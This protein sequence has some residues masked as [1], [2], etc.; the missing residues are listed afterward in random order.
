VRR[1]VRPARLAATD[2][3]AMQRLSRAIGGAILLA[4]VMATPAAAHTLS[5]REAKRFAQRVVAELGATTY[6]TGLGYVQV[7]VRRG[8]KDRHWVNCRARWPYAYDGDA[9]CTGWIGVRYRSSH[10]RKKSWVGPLLEDCW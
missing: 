5:E 9:T 1:R 2:E 10:S 6:Y 3:P 4:V 7:C 8:G